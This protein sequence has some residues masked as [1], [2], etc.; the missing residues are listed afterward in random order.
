M[1]GTFF[2]K[3]LEWNIETH[4]ESWNQGDKITGTLKVKN[5][6]PEA[7]TL[8]ESGVALAHAEIKKVH[9]RT[10]GA[11]KIDAKEEF[12]DSQIAPQETK[13]LPFSLNLPPNC[14]VTDKKASYFLSYGKNFSESH[15]QLKVEPKVLFNKIIG[16][17]D[18]FHRFKLKEVKAG[19]QGVEYKLL[20]PTSREM[21]NLESLNLNFSMAED[22]LKMDFDFQVRKLD[23]A[24][25]TTKVNKASVKLQ[26]VLTPKEFSLGRDMINQDQLLKSLE[27]VLSEVKLKSVF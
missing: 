15:L 10:E 27:S 24:S 5:H 2:N 8:N 3:P 13:E 25:V 4:A 18:T 23:T 7:I 11:F 6:G 17:L 26:R 19:K 1:K 22:N 16:L 14:A 9:S 20:P 12:K 21:A